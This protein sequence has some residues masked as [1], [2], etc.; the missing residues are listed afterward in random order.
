MGG[1][2]KPGAESYGVTDGWRAP[3]SRNADLSPTM[4]SRTPPGGPWHTVY[5]KR[6]LVAGTPNIFVSVFT[7]H[8]DSDNSVVVAQMAKS[9]AIN[10]APNG[11]DVTVKVGL[12]GGGVL[13]VTFG[14][15]DKWSLRRLKSTG[16]PDS[17]LLSATAPRSQLLAEDLEPDEELL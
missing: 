7:P 9:T 13:D 11:G 8:A 1:N 5:S 14:S 6:K 15:D 12:E 17:T 3:A 4:P 2:A 10:S 16:I